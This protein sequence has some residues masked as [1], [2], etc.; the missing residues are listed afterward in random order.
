MNQNEQCCDI[1]ILHICWTVQA[2]IKSETWRNS[3][4]SSTRNLLTILTAWANKPSLQGHHTWVVAEEARTN[5]T[6]ITISTSLL[7][8]SCPDYKIKTVYMNIL[9]TPKPYVF[10][11][12]M[13]RTFSPLV[14]SIVPSL[15]LKFIL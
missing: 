2:N 7:M 10:R 12:Q 14:K 9:R 4:D 11:K 5:V 8:Q 1:Q 3:R 15:Y 6:D 13:E